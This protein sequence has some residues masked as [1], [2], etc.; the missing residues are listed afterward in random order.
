M[1]AYAKINLKLNIISK[2]SDGYHSLDM[3]M[4]EIDLFDELII[5]KVKNKQNKKTCKSLKDNNLVIKAA[6]LMCQKYNLP[7][8]SLSFLLKKNIPI[9]A[10][11]GGGSSDCANTIIQ[12]NKLFSL[13]LS[14]DSLIS[15]ATSLGADVPFFIKGG[16]M[17]CEG[18][19][20]KLTE[21]NGLLNEYILLITPNIY[22]STKTIFEE[23]DLINNNN[24]NSKNIYTNDLEKITIKKYPLIEDIKLQLIKCKA[25]VSLM[26]GSG[27]SVY[28]LFDIETDAK[29][30]YNIIKKTF[31]ENIRYIGIHKAINKR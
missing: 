10:G 31:S 2:R 11:L 22:I 23:Y 8:E 14:N 21:A 15:I 12:I 29:N 18:I 6:R 3:I 4:Q 1:K 28:G 26:S 30:A 13:N 16:C 19:G 5:T 24:I 9:S 25:K 20:E 17:K 7:F 27:S